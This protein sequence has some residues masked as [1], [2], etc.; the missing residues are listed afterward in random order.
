MYGKNVSKIDVPG[1]G[2]SG[3]V[4]KYEYDLFECKYHI[5]K[6]WRFQIVIRRIP[7]F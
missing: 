5:Y 6:S 2:V 1:S 7:T 4:M 3:T